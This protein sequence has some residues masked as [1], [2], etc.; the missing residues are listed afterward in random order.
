MRVPAIRFGGCPRAIHAK[1]NGRTLSGEQNQNYSSLI[2]SV[3]NIALYNLFW[4]S[5]IFLVF[6]HV[7]LRSHLQPLI[8]SHFVPCRRFAPA[9]AFGG[10]QQLNRGL[11]NQNNYGQNNGERINLRER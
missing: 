5:V 4:L 1:K 6:V 3:L 9:T 11:F 8:A 2:T 7:F 10:Q